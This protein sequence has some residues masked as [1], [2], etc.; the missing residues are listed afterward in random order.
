MQNP[1]EKT[2]RARAVDSTPNCEIARMHSPPPRY[3]AAIA[4]AGRALSIT[5]PTMIAPIVP[6]TWNI[7]V[8]FAAVEMS[9][10]A[11]FISVGSQPVRSQKVDDHQAH[12]VRDP[13]RDRHPG[14]ALRE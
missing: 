4:K 14:I 10:P 12:E 9:R 3:A 8:T 5:Q 13:Q 2:S 1:A 6:P 7:A 11:S